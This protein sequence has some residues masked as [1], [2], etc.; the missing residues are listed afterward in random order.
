MKQPFLVAPVLFAVVL[1][2]HSPNAAAQCTINQPIWQSL[3]ACREA[4]GQSFTACQTGFVTSLSFYSAS[5]ATVPATLGLQAG[6]NLV[7]QSNPQSVN[8]VPGLNTVVL[9]TPLSVTNGTLYSFGLARVGV[10]VCMIWV[11]DNPY[12]GG[13][14]I[15][16]QSGTSFPQANYDLDFSVEIVESPVSTQSASWGSIKVLY[17]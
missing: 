16:Y 9:D 15:S 12:A 6:T 1:A 10:N 4:Q 17:R 7:P 2:I 13:T 14:V 11:S 8:I 5:G 3:G